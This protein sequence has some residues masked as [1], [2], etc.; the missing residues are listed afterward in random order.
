MKSDSIPLL[1]PIA[2]TRRPIVGGNK[3]ITFFKAMGLYED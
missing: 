3:E 1:K 2:P